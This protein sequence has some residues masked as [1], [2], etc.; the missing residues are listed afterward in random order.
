MD[1][2]HI[3]HLSHWLR[4]QLGTVAQPEVALL[5]AYTNDVYRVEVEGERFAL[6]LYGVGWRDDAAIRWEIDLLHHL[7]RQGVNV[8]QPVPDRNGEALGEVVLDG[9]RRQAVL[10][11]W[12]DGSKP[13]APFTPAMYRRQGMAAATIHLAADGFTSPYARPPLDLDHLIAQPIAFIETIPGNHQAKS[14]LRSIADDLSAAITSL[15]EQGLDWGPCHGDL[16]FDNVHHT[17]EGKTVWY[18]FDSGGPGWRAID[19][20]GWAAT[21]PDRQKDWQAFLAGYQE[22][23][24]LNERDIAAAPYLHLAQDVWSVQLDLQHRVIARGPEAI[25]QLLAERCDELV[26]R[27]RAL[28]LATA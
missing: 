5:R 8:A 24:P 6:K 10:F 11:A 18:D 17:A 2:P 16:T 12:A 26:S 25:S 14:T 28:G 22:V 20:Q 27:A 1:I 9:E 13:K 15:A 4:E 19:L 21:M 23:R 3:L 7:A